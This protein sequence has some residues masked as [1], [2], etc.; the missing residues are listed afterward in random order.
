VCVGVC[1][2]VCFSGVCML[3]DLTRFKIINDCI[4]ADDVSSC[5]RVF[6]CVCVC[7]MVF[8]CM[9]VCVC[10]S[11]CVCVC[12]R[13]FVLVCVRVCVCVCECVF[14]WCVYAQ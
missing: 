8:V 12:V 4:L 1:E 5:V 7:F 10:V 14:E 2:C 3:N 9:R 6:L 13:V 11:V